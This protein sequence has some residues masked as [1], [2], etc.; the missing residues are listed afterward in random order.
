MVIC[1]TERREM[2]YKLWLQILCTWHFDENQWFPVFG[3]SGAFENI[4][5]NVVQIQ[6]QRCTQEH[7]WS[8]GLLPVDN[9]LYIELSLDIAVGDSGAR[10]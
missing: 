4:L 8:G 1:D 3:A 10:W 6:R 2:F 5:K 9:D 7:T